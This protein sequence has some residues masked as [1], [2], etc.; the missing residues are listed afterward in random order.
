VQRAVQRRVI[1]Q[2]IDPAIGIQ[3]RLRHRDG[4]AHVVTSSV[5]PIACPT[6]ARAAA[7]VA[8]QSSTSPATIL[9]RASQADGIFASQSARRAGDQHNF[10]LNR[11]EVAPSLS[12][13]A[14]CFIAPPPVLRPA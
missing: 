14:G 2:R 5:T 12:D 10:V 4:R 3:R 9:P 11:H 8:A 6:A 1:H 7:T 13:C